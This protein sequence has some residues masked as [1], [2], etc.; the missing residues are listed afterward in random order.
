MQ[1]FQSEVG[2]RQR[3]PDVAGT[4]VQTDR[5]RRNGNQTGRFQQNS[6]H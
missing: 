5:G 3:K 4:V 2:I 6:Y 1:F